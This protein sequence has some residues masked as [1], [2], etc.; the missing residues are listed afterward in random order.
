MQYPLILVT[1]DDGIQSPGLWAVA[2]AL[3]PLGEVIVVA[4]DRQ[5]SGAGRALPHD[6]TGKYYQEI[7]SIHGKQVVAYAVDG[8]PAQ[9]VQHGVLE[10]TPRVPSLVVSGI[11]SGANL[12]IEVTISGT[13]GAYWAIRARASAMIGSI[14]YTA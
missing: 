8:S 14:S 7:R 4:P 9:M 10:M 2:E 13:V 11:N 6:V 5:W 3:L 1:N 12:S